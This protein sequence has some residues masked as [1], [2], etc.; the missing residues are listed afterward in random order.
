MARG[1]KPHKPTPETRR[2]AKTLSGL[3]VPQEHICFMLKISMP[4]LHKHYRDDL[5][6]GMAEANAKI[7][8]TLFKQALNGN[9]TAAI[10]WAKSR[11]GWR[12]KTD[13]EITGAGG[14]PVQIEAIR[15]TIVDPK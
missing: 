8:E 4:T 15:R 13:L 9:T 11:M 1:Q 5:D 10:F 14:G 12:E 7:A 3:G 6:E 2:L